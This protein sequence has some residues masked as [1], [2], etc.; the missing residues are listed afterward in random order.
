MK[1]FSKSTVR[2]LAVLMAASICFSVSAPAFA[3][4]GADTASSYTASETSDL[5]Q[6]TAASITSVKV[7]YNS[8]EID[9]TNTPG[10]VLEI[11]RLSILTF[12]VK[13]SKALS[14]T[15]GTGSVAHTGTLSTY[16]SST[17]ESR[18]NVTAVGALGTASGL[19]LDGQK[20]FAI[21][22]GRTPFVCDT[23]MP[24]TKTVGQ[25]YTFKVTAENTTDKISFH[26]GNG[27]VAATAA[28]PVRT[29]NGKSAYYFKLTAASAG[30]TDRKSVV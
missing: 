29:E 14:Y 23:T 18:Y 30:R 19:F 20:I 24:V 7:T 28:Q 21:K 25:S 17:G 26:V 11:P 3:A 12:T 16:N 4:D 5:R 10:T 1:H 6:A 2:I 9:V 22:V 15:A 13:S 8:K 27:A